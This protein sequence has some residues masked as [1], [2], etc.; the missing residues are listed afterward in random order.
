[1]HSYQV[2]SAENN[3]MRMLKDIQTTQTVIQ[4]NKTKKP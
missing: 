1:M 2:I 3:I 4:E